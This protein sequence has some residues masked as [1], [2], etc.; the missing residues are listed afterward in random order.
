MMTI[1]PCLSVLNISITF[2]SFNNLKPKMQSI[3]ASEADGIISNN[4]GKVNTEI[5]NKIP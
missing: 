1:A 2:F 5:S 4:V 3:A